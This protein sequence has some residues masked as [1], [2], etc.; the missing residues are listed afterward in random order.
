MS[1]STPSL[2]LP[3]STYCWTE[4][5]QKR[6]WDPAEFPHLA[7]ATIV[8]PPMLLLLKFAVV[9][10]EENGLRGYVFSSPAFGRGGQAFTA[11]R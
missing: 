4:A 1:G 8:R 5:T 7:L 11:S 6:R 9:T 10:I 2:P 3:S